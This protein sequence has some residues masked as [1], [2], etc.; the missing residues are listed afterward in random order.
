MITGGSVGIGLA[1]ARALAEE[2]VHIAI[3]ARN[4]DRAKERAAEIET[5]FGVTAIGVKAD[6]TNTDDLN[7]LVETVQE[8]F[9]MAL[10]F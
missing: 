5:D 2:G 6:V 9:D 7:S 4:G 1:V 10:I 3:C 8:T